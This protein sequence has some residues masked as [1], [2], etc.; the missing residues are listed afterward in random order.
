MDKLVTVHP[1]NGIPLSYE[2]EQTMNPCNNVR[3]LENMLSAK[4]PDTRV[5]SLV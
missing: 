2:K 4:K 1:Y 3:T 5:H